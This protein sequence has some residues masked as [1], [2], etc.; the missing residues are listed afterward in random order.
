MTMSK[1]APGPAGFTLF[2]LMITIAVAAVLAAIAVPNMRD[3]L[4][5]GRLTSA[6]NEMLRAMQIAR[7]EAI[8]RQLP[9]AVCASANPS[10]TDPTCSNGSFTGW[11]VF[12]DSNNDWQWGAGEEVLARQ[13][14]DDGVAVVN[15]NLGMVS[16]ANTGFANSTPGKTATTR[17]VICDSRGNSQIGANSVARAV[18]IEPAGRSRISREYADVTAAL[19]LIGDSCP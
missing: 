16:Y 1:Q 10:A 4:R 14:V 7:S 15:N 12:E 11:I 8:K 3:F 5:N 2:E 19:T 18:I 13:N 17:I 9:V 6:A